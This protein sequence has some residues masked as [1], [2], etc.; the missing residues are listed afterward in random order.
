MRSLPNLY[1]V[2]QAL[3]TSAQLYAQ[4]KQASPH[5]MNR[6]TFSVNLNYIYNFSAYRSELSNTY[7]AGTPPNY[8]GTD[9]VYYEKH[10]NTGASTFGINIAYNKRLSKRT[11]LSFGIGLNQKQ[12][13]TKYSVY[14]DR[15]SSKPDL[16]Y[17]M[18]KDYALVFNI[19]LNY[20]YQRFIFN[21]GNNFAYSIVQKSINTY[22]DNSQKY[23]RCTT[24]PVNF[25]FQES[26]SYQLIRNKNLYLK[27]SAEQS[28]RFYKPYG[29]NNWFML[30]GTYYF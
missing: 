13:V 23:D 20:Y 11:A 27:V 24:I 15:N 17:T 6:N 10:R 30:G 2:L 12:Q 29:Y 16:L 9:T 7:L 14:N 19:S 3:F 1:I 21:A 18:V 8:N 28:E 4:T 5:H 25:Y 26:V 22:E